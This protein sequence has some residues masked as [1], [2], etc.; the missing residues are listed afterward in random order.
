MSTWSSQPA[1]GKSTSP[2][3]LDDRSIGF[4][5]GAV[6][7]GTLFLALSSQIEVPM[8]PVPVTM[9]TFAVALVGALFGARLGTLTVLVWLGEALLGLPVLA[10]GAG[11]IAHFA[12]PTAG[13]L[14]AF[15]VMAAML[16]ALAERGWDAGRPLLAFASMLAANALCLVMGAAW[17]SSLI[18][19]E[20]A[21]AL[22]VTPFILGAV[23]KS[24]LGSASLVALQRASSKARQP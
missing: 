1:I 6:L 22:G 8:V 12:G 17:L 5:A 15:P 24:A 21:I 23:L 11:G 13:Y 9:Q 3:R 14:A 4:K 16:G 18:G 19:I 2:L 20:K 7:V 10:G